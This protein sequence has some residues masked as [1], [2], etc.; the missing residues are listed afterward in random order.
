MYEI[1]D[2]KTTL[3]RLGTAIIAMCCGALGLI[4]LALLVSQLH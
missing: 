2:D 3:R 4:A 1:V